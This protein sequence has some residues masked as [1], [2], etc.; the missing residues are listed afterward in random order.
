MTNDIQI[1]A[2][3]V[4]F[5]G[6]GARLHRFAVD[7]DGTVRVFDRVAGHFTSCHALS[8]RTQ[9]RIRKLARA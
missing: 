8:S 5:T 2:R 4:A 6:E 7:V 3:A 9:A 1:T